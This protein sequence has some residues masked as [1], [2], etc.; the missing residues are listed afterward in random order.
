MELGIGV[1]LKVFRSRGML[2]HSI[3]RG[4]NKDKTATSE[5][6][7]FN[8]ASS[9]NIQIEHKDAKGIFNI[10]IYI[11]IGRR[12]APKEAYRELCG[13]FHGARPS[14]RRL[15]KQLKKEE[16]RSKTATQDQIKDSKLMKTLNYVQNKQKTPYLILDSKTTAIF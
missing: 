7:K 6:A 11:Y 13:R 5:L 10:Y 16:L 14:K 9:D 3:E 8:P 4:R 2:G 1:A 15:L 12:L